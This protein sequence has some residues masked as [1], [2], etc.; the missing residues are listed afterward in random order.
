MHNQQHIL[1]KS[2]QPNRQEDRQMIWKVLRNY[3]NMWHLSL[4]GGLKIWKAFNIR[5]QIS[6]G[7][8]QSL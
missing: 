7:N 4:G 3:R 6:E 8:I 1:C 5:A 2:R